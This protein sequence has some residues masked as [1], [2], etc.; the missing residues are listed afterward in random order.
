MYDNVGGMAYCTGLLLANMRLA[1][2]ETDN[3]QFI[4]VMYLMGIIP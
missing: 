2:L 4:S 1:N 3:L